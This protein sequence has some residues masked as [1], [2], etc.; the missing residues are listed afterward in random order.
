MGAGALLLV[1]CG[2]PDEPEVDAANVWGEQLRVSQ[3]ALAAYPSI[4]LRS[5]AAK[6]VR[7]LESQAGATGTA[8]TA[9]RSLQTALEAERVAL[10][11]HVA[12]VGELEDRASRELL[13]TLIAGTAEAVSALR[14]EMDEPPIVDAFPGQRNRP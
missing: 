1:G 3:A 12:A 7:Q 13:A 6:R 14:A 10:Q 5:A 4:A 8:P 11:A 2:P 9:T